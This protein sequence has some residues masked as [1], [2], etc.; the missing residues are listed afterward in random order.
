MDLNLD[1]F[2]INDFVVDIHWNLAALQRVFGEQ[3]N[4]EAFRLGSICATDSSHW[5]W[6]PKTPHCSSLSSKV[7]G[8]LVNCS[9]FGDHWLG[10]KLLWSLNIALVLNILLGW[11]LRAKLRLLSSFMP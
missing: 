6:F 9:G 4:T 11:C 7:Y 8:H 1:G 3:I 10:W 2:S 5:V